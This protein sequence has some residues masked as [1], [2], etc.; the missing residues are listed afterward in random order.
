[1]LL[2]FSILSTLNA[3]FWEEGGK[4]KAL[5]VIGKL[6]FHAVGM[7]VAWPYGFEIDFLR[8]PIFR[9]A[10][11]FLIIILKFIL[12]AIFYIKI[13]EKNSLT[14]KKFHFQSPI[15]IYPIFI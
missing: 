5:P 8:N 4:C 3:Q 12:T 2:L 6:K 1:M 14:P 13:H 11:C 7:A 15:F 10:A 9:S